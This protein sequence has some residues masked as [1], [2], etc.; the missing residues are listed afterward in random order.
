MIRNALKEDLAEIIAL[1]SISHLYPWGEK[2]IK[3]ALC[4]RANWVIETGDSSNKKIVGWLTASTILNE[5]ELEL[6]LIH[7]SYRRQGLAKELMSTWLSYMETKEV[8]SFFLEVRE[9]NQ[10]AI[11]LYEKMGFSQVGVRKNYYPA[12]TGMENALLMSR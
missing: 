7:S 11:F 3:D 9:S 4:S 12:A 8:D 2:L 1:D 10:S 5:S 6:V